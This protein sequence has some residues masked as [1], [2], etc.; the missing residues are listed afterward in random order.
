M[1]LSPKNNAAWLE[2]GI[3]VSQP[4][5]LSLEEW[6]E[7]AKILKVMS[8]PVRL[9]ILEE[10]ARGSRCVKDIN[11]LIPDLPQPHLSQ[12]MSALRKAELVS[13]HS[14][15][16]LRCYYV[17]RPTLVQQVI[18]ILRMEHPVLERPREAIRAEARGEALNI[19]E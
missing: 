3:S 11:S 6:Q 2:E 18:A 19:P 8:H 16:P 13:S 10:L 15:G 7:R 14:D 4:V 1:S 5:S 12:H 17:L 9:L